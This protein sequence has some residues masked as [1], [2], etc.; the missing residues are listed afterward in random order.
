MRGLAAWSFRHRRIVVIGWLLALV[1]MSGLSKAVGT[2][3]SNTFDLPNTES[4]KAIELLQAAAPKQAG[5][6]AN[7]VIGTTGGTKVTDPDVQASVEAMLKKLSALPHVS[8]IVSP[9]D[10]AGAGQVSQDGTVAFAVVTF[11]TQ[12]Q[13]I[14]IPAAQTF[15]NTARAA[16]GRT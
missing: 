2:A 15:V 3:Y 6:T 8:T 7:I 12:A 1:L 13:F 16:G 10:P 11:D 14:S 9:Y 5:D 4:T